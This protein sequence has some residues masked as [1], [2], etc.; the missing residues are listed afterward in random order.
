[1]P[2]PSPRKSLDFVSRTVANGYPGRVKRLA[3]VLFYSAGKAIALCV[4]LK[5]V[6]PLSGTHIYLSTLLHIF[7]LSPLRL[8][9]FE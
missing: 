7:W 5:S 4:S 3:R 1:M 6:R 2:R 9:T 8:F